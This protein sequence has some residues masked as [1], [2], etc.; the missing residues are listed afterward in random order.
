MSTYAKVRKA[1]LEQHDANG[2]NAAHAR[3]VCCGDHAE[4]KVLS[5]LGGRC[6]TC[7]GRYLREPRQHA[8]LPNVASRASP[9]GWALRLQAR[10]QAGETLTPLQ[11]AMWRQALLIT[12]RSM[13][14]SDA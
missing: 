1:L 2:Q 5:T 10:E 13:E 14:D 3:C 6:S 4:F 12:E 9:R 7:Y 8:A 11:R